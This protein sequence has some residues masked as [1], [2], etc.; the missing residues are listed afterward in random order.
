MGIKSWIINR[1][2][3]DIESSAGHI[4]LENLTEEDR[5]KLFKQFGEGDDNLTEFLR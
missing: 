5:E 2:E 4:E 3:K 1:L